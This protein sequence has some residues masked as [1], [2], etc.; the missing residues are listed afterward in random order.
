MQAVRRRAG[1][2]LLLEWFI[3]P[4]LVS[5]VC[6]PLTK[7]TKHKRKPLQAVRSRS[8]C[9][10]TCFQLRSGMSGLCAL[11]RATEELNEQLSDCLQISSI[12]E[13]GLKVWSIWSFLCCILTQCMLCVD[14]CSGF[15]R[16]RTQC[17][18]CTSKWGQATAA[19]YGNVLNPFTVQ[20]VYNPFTILSESFQNSS[21]SFLSDFLSIL[22]WIS[23][24]T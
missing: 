13:Q 7:E 9:C 2:Q 11:P 10:I 3:E 17:G 14:H 15:S 6:G 24:D 20:S 19:A 4:G 23:F 18:H 5:G 22:L 12:F 16:P 8:T 21:A 1:G